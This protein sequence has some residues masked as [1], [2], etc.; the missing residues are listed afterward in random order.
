[1]GKKGPLFLELRVDNAQCTRKRKN[2]GN[3][4]VVFS[5][6]NGRRTHNKFPLAGLFGSSFFRIPL[7]NCHTFSIVVRNNN[8][9]DS[10]R[11][12]SF[13]RSLCLAENGYHGFRRYSAGGCPF[14]R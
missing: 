7:P 13:A 5:F 12:P 4:C 11:Q 3:E 10:A 8:D 6:N 14:G 1:M 9:I 2:Q